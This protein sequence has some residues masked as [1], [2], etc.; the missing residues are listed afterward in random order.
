MSGIEVVLPTS[1]RLVSLDHLVT[2]EEWATDWSQ[3]AER[4]ELV[5]GAPL[6]SPSEHPDNGDATT[7]LLIRLLYAL[8]EE[9]RF[10]QHINVGITS[11]GRLTHRIPDLTVLRQDSPRDNPLDPTQ[12]VLVAEVLS[13]ST[14]EEDLGRKRRDYASVSIPNYVLVDRE[15]PPRLRVLTDPLDGDYR[16]EQAGESVTLSIAGHD[17]I[18]AATEI[19]RWR[20]AAVQKTRPPPSV[21]RPREEDSAA[22]VRPGRRAG[23]PA[24]PA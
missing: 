12:V 15:G 24:V 1:K 11:E 22:P 21:A 7:M 16:S 5:D 6:M 20:Q 4:Y 13:A 2:H 3:R 23:D 9:W 18:L 10:L 17:I 19:I 8:G 14:R